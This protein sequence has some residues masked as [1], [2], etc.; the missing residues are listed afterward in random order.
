M[1]PNTILMIILIL[2]LVIMIV[3]NFAHPPPSPPPSPVPVP[4][5]VPALIKPIGGCAGSR[6]GCCPNGITSRVNA[7]GTNCYTLS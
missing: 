5:P 6:Y 1:D 3:K 4:I 7:I 2:L